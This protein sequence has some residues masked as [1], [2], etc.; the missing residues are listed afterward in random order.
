[1]KKK[2]VL[3]SLIIL[4]ILASGCSQQPE[5]PVE[6]EVK[7]EE[8]FEKWFNSTINGDWNNVFIN[9][10]DSNGNP[11][12]E[13]CKDSFKKSLGYRVGAQYQLN[14][15]NISEEEQCRELP[16]YQ[17]LAE[18]FNVS[19]PNGQCVI[20]S[21]S[22]QLKYPNGD[23]SNEETDS[24][25]LKVNN[26]W[27]V[28]IDCSKSVSKESQKLNVTEEYNVDKLNLAIDLP[29]TSFKVNESFKGKFIVENKGEPF[30][31]FIL[32]KCRNKEKSVGGSH[33]PECVDSLQ[34]LDTAFE[35]VI[36]GCSNVPTTLSP[37]AV[38]TYNPSINYC[39]DDY[40]MVPGNYSFEIKVYSCSQIT[41]TT[42]E[43]NCSSRDDLWK[44][45]AIEY[46][47]T[48]IKTIIKNVTV[49]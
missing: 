14:I 23:T 24:F 15:K 12:S 31:A 43:V 39:Y 7:P 28:I 13:D 45:A 4:I 42:N 3:L 38:N 18:I 26:D 47:V 11:Y 19:I 34:G 41:A 37:G 2:L 20:I 21:Y 44:E 16:E 5:K 30:E 29:K 40:F 27:K 1:M 36:K 22:V 49:T 33:L 25:L 46:Y 10:V 48:P 17:R 9:M 35:K 6:N 32:F 8:V